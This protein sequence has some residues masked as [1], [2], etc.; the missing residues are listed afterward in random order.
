MKRSLGITSTHDLTTRLQPTL[1]KWLRPSNP[2]IQGQGTEMISLSL[3]SPLSKL[4]AEL[5]LSIVFFLPYTSVLTLKRTNRYFYYFLTTPILNECKEIQ[6]A[7]FAEQEKIGGWLNEFPC[8]ACLRL[9]NE[10]EFY[11]NGTYATT[12]A[13]PGTADTNRHC[14]LCSFALN[15]YEPGTCLT[16]NG[17]T[18]VLC[19]NCGELEKLPLHTNAKVCTPCKRSYDNRQE[20]GTWLR[21]AQLFF[22][23]VSWALSCSGALVPRTSLA[24]RNSLRFIFQSILVRPPFPLHIHIFLLRLP[25]HTPTQKVPPHPL[26]HSKLPPHPQRNKE[27]ARVPHQTLSKREIRL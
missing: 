1:P 24:D 3:D 27:M 10:H 17:E 2:A 8:Y 25:N 16:I 21:L 13:S 26:R 19:A 6:I 4:P 18:K 5:Q 15:E 14:I 11:T 22:T 12:L 7:R 9:K 23:I 20:N